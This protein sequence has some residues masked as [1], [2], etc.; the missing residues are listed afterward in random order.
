LEVLQLDVEAFQCVSKHAK[1]FT[2]ISVTVKTTVPTAENYKTK[3][4]ILISLILEKK[5]III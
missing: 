2:S 3:L 5:K 1:W 4:E